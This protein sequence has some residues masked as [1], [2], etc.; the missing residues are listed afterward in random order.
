MNYLRIA[1]NPPTLNRKADLLVALLC[2]F[3]SVYLLLGPQEIP[4]PQN[5][6]GIPAVADW[7]LTM[8]CVV[9]DENET[10]AAPVRTRQNAKI[11]MASFII[12][13]LS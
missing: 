8:G 6:I 5:G 3:S 7:W 11:R 12:G 4:G 13:N 2:Y 9:E 10:A 1:P